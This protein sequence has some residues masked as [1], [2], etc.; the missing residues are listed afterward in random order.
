MGAAE[1]LSMFGLEKEFVSAELEMIESLT[2]G[3]AIVH[4]LEP[5]YYTAMGAALDAVTMPA[6]A[7]QTEATLPMAPPTTD[8]QATR[9]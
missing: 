6:E 8:A 4:H 3:T 1:A 5:S 7:Q 9:D 2:K